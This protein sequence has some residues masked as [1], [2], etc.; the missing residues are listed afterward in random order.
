MLARVIAALP[1]IV[2]LSETN[3]RSAALFGG[4]LNPI[5]QIRNWLP[6]FVSSVAT[7]D[8]HELGYPPRFGEMLES[9]HTS[10]E[11]LGFTLVVRD[12][13]YVD[14]VG[15]PFVWP[16]PRDLSLDQAV[17][18]RFTLAPVLLVRHPADQLASLRTHRSIQPNLTAEHF[19]NSYLAFLLAMRGTPLFRYEDIVDDPQGV[20]PQICACMGIA[21]DSHALDRFSSIE[22]VT[23]NMRRSKDMEIRKPQKTEAASL[24]EEELRR[25]SSYNVLLSEMGYYVC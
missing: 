13:N 19:V 6:L 11:K 10:A 4:L 15:V 8:K 18:G 23:G 20:F 5:I 14:F 7:F 1:G 25:F 17:L 9:L 3:L 12:Y 22:T 2:I 16:V 24:A 21:W